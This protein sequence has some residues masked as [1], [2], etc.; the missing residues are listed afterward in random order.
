MLQCLESAGDE[1]IVGG[2]SLADSD[3]DDAGLLTWAASCEKQF[4]TPGQQ[5]RERI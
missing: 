5:S 3:N 2:S 4:E 1:I